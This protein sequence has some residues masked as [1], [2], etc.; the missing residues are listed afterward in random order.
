MM[1]FVPHRKRPH[2]QCRL[3]DLRE[4]FKKSQNDQRI[5]TQL[6]DEL[7]FRKRPAAR[8]LRA[9]VERRI[10]EI[11]GAK[12]SQTDSR[13]NRKLPLPIRQ[14]TKEASSGS[15]VLD[16][17]ESAQG[18]S[19]QVRRPHPLKQT[20][21]GDR[22]S[23]RTP[24]V[25]TDVS[26][27]I[28]QDMP[29][30]KR[31]IAAL[32]ALI[33]DMRA[34]RQ[35]S[36]QI[37]LEIGTRVAL[38]RGHNGYSFP[39]VED[40]DL[41]EDARVELRIG[42]QRI[43]GQIASIS[44]GK[45]I[46][47]VEEDLGEAITHCL[48][49]IDNTALIEALKERLEKAGKEGPALNTKLA[50]TVVSKNSQT[51]AIAS[52]PVE[53]NFGELNEKQRHAVGHALANEVTYLWGPPG[54]GKTSTLA[55]LIEELLAGN[56][57]TLICSN[58]NKAVDQVLRRFCK[59]LSEKHPACREKHPAV[60]EG[61]IVR[62]GR[63][64]DDEL[65]ANYANYVT[66]D[67]IV[68]RPSR[69]LQRRKAELETAVEA[70]ARR[71]RTIEAT[72]SRF[73]ELDSV[74]TA[75]ANSAKELAQLGKEND[76][77]G[78]KREA[79]ERR[80]AKLQKEIER[81]RT[82]GPLRRMFM[83]SEQKIAA[84]AE[85]TKTAKASAEDKIARFRQLLQDAKE[86]AS[87]LNYNKEELVRGLAGVDR[88]AVK[89]VAEALASERQP[90]LDELVTINRALADMK[91]AVMRDAAVIGTTVTKVFLSAKDLP[92]FDI[93]IVDEA[94]MVI[95]PALYFAT[96]LAREKVVISGDFRQLPPIV[97]TQQ[98]TIIDEIGKD[99]FHAAGIVEAVDGGGGD[100]RVEM[101]QE[102]HRMDKAICGLI[103]ERMYHGRLYSSPEVEKRASKAREPLSGPLTIVDTSSLWPFESQ[104]ATFS[105]YNLVHAILVRNL[106]RRLYEAGHTKDPV[107][108]GVCTPYAAQAKLIRRLIEDD[109]F[110]LAKNVGTVHRYQ[111]D[112]KT[113]IIMD[114]PESVGGAWSIGQFLSGE[115][116]D[117][118]NTKLLN[119]AVSRAKEN[120]VIVANL[121]Y[122]D[123]RLSERSFL[124]EILDR[125]RSSGQVLDGKE[126]LSLQAVDLRGW[127]WSID[128][129]PETLRTG[130]FNQKD[131]DSAFRADVS[132]A[133]ESV[134]IFSGFVTPERVGSYGDLFRRKILE[135]VKIRCVTRP[136]KYNGSIPAPM[137]KEAL[138]ALESIGVVVDCRR[139]IHQKIAIIDRQTVWVGSLNTLSY[140]AKTDEIMMRVVAPRFASELARQIAIRY[141]AG[142]EG[143]AGQGENPRC[144]KCSGRTEYFWSRRYRKFFFA[145]ESECGWI[146]EP[147]ST[148]RFEQSRSA[149]DLPDDGP[150]CPKCGHE[151]R[152][153]N[154]RYG[155]FFGCSRYPECDGRISGQ[156]ALDLMNDPAPERL[157]D[158]GA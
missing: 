151:T 148:G 141:R 24:N 132:Q 100:P 99:V 56:K 139:R 108:F 78:Q 138:D 23:A 11:T 105:R 54:T 104:T 44:D 110:E 144:G 118:D 17:G 140:T 81:A 116:S 73:T 149:D 33:V 40:A 36:R 7:A 145:C 69:D 64:A 60:E 101:L 8:A 133:K 28:R 65:K 53:T 61:R 98:K 89:K 45:L 130:L 79:A 68:V 125:M 31:Y 119:V 150:Q 152:R 22:S 5:L 113:I 66:L 94:S 134:L 29:R 93:V 58:T 10:H 1:L 48:L 128:L 131:F 72:L 97:Q 15:Q 13:E 62:L 85:R 107:D 77:A 91:A 74:Q 111:G 135:G 155:S 115:H 126:I 6:A 90:H 146:K 129:D 9:E 2:I 70:S 63:I 20:E 157:L 158:E 32:A 88:A 137:G 52:S 42:G 18:N 92:A 38:D 76:S 121:T 43:D 35:G 109:D 34:N 83:R 80:L 21:P 12:V 4:L 39:F 122:L 41:F 50:D 49:V 84:D 95:Q 51:V 46:I 120:L 127:G 123:P 71:E 147:N 55:V 25:K 16:A 114:L 156:R 124:R 82:A 143:A 37:T 27:P 136:P 86:K 106:V 26:L 3:R 103:S 19:V 75:M 112:Q 67:G 47:A 87:G 117:D 96:G 142:V 14:R 59:K 30:V 57:R 102:Q 153:R 154:S